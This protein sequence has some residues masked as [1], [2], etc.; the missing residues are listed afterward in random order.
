MAYFAVMRNTVLASSGKSL[1]SVTYRTLS[2]RSPPAPFPLKV[3]SARHILA[4]G[5]PFVSLPELDRVLG[6]LARSRGDELAYYLASIVEASE[7]Q[8]LQ[9]T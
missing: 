5:G 7:M 4:R 6:P 9:M 1:S 8:S 3:Q 2:P